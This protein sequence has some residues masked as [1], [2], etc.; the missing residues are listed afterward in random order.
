MMDPP[1]VIT[2]GSVTV[3]V[4]DSF[5]PDPKKNG[6]YKNDKK[7]IKRITIT[8]AGIQNYE[9]EAKNNNITVTIEYENE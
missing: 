8:G 4:P 3:D 7:K 9:A 1:I 5:T 6:S 2:G